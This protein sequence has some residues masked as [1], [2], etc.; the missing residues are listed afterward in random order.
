MTAESTRRDFI[1]TVGLG[2]AFVGAKPVFAEGR[3][4]AA[5]LPPQGAQAA[6]VLLNYNESPYGPSPKAL[7][8]IRNA[9]VAVYSRYFPEDTYDSLRDALAAHHGVTRAH[10]RMGAGSTEILKVCDDIFVRPG[11]PIVVAEPAYEAVLQYAANS[12]AES[13]KVPLTA[14]HRHDLARMAAAT[15]A[16]TGMVYVCN[17]NNP[18]GTIVRREIGRAHV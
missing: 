15:T 1:K 9:E 8:A 18:T 7:A 11:A 16:D 3:A 17:P 4:Y 13:V 6:N 14:D 5:A 2:A 12:K 10:I